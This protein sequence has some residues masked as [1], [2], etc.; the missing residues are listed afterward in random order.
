MAAKVTWTV[1]QLRGMTKLLRTIRRCQNTPKRRPDQLPTVAEVNHFQSCGECTPI[2]SHTDTVPDSMSPQKTTNVISDK[3]VRASVPVLGSLMPAST[4]PRLIGRRLRSHQHDLWTKRK[5]QMALFRHKHYALILAAVS[6]LMCHLSGCQTANSI[7]SSGRRC[8][9]TFTSPELWLWVFGQPCSSWG[10]YPWSTSDVCT[11]VDRLSK[12]LKMQC[13]WSTVYDSSFWSPW[14]LAVFLDIW[15]LPSNQAADLSLLFST[16]RK[17]IKVYK[18]GSS[19][20][21]QRPRDTGGH[22]PLSV[23]AN[24]LLWSEPSCGA[25]SVCTCHDTRNLAGEQ[26]RM[27]RTITHWSLLGGGCNCRAVSV[28]SQK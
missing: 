26:Q 16:N 24:D 19:L 9:K 10:S 22:M 28:R 3:Y 5:F 2:H 23:W 20:A 27:E 1:W 17:R 14:Y 18:G 6:L 7:G 21:S 25:A 15:V 11:K 12:N 13:M 8:F 4:Q